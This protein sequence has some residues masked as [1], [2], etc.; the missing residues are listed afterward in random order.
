MRVPTKSPIRA[1]R[2]ASVA[3]FSGLLVAAVPFSGAQAATYSRTISGAVTCNAVGVP[4][5]M[6][7]E[8][9]GGLSNG[10]SGMWVDL[11]AD[12]KNKYRATFSK[13]FPTKGKLTSARLDIGCGGNSKT[14]R[15]NNSTPFVGVSGTKNLGEAICNPKTGKRAERCVVVPGGNGW[16]YPI[17]PHSSIT[18]YVRHPAAARDFPQ[19]NGKPVYAM[20]GGKAVVRTVSASD[21][22]TWCKSPGRVNG[23]QREIIITSTVGG[24]SY[25]LTYA[26]FS[27]F[28]IKNGATVKTGQRI[29][30]VG[31]SGCTSGYHLHIDV[32][33]NGKAGS[34]N[35]AS[36]LRKTTRY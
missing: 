4:V 3:A 18:T 9:K 33:V 1:F 31:N 22:A 27:K 5:G 23:G 2:F 20:Q 32:L 28:L 34:V 14:W 35:P 17:R 29:G 24:N 21:V 15:S 7:V 36:L 8:V 11:K 26:H 25:K 12:S 13:N 19:P 10:K 16:A 30:D 6:W